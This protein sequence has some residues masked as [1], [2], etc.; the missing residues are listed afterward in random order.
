MNFFLK[1]LMKYLI[2]HTNNNTMNKLSAYLGILALVGGFFMS[3]C[4][5]DDAE[6]KV[7]SYQESDGSTVSMGELCG[8][9]YKTV[10]S[11]GFVT[12]TGHHAVTCTD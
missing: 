3:S 4:T 12:S 10:E 1:L 6:C 2:N 9:E 5:K 7:C 11:S 8:S